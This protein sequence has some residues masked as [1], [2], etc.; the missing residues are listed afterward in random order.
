[1]LVFFGTEDGHED[2]D[3]AQVL[4]N[5]RVGDGHKTDPGIL[6]FLQDVAGFPL[7]L[8]LQPLPAGDAHGSPSLRR[9]MGCRVR[10]ARWSSPS[11]PRPERPTNSTMVDKTCSA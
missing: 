8:F 3:V 10:A 1:L 2:L 11:A 6:H 4:G 7:E 5:L 9:G